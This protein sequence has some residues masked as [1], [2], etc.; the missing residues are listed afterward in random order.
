MWFHLY[1]E[2]KNTNKKADSKEKL[3][4][5]RGMEGIGGISEIHEGD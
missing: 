5:A 4:V 1:V 3:V 2:S